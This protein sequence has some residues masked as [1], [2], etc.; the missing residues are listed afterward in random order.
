MRILVTGCA[1]FIGYA[2]CDELLRTENEVLGI[3]R[4]SDYYSVDLKKLRLNRLGIQK[5]FDF[6]QTDIASEKTTKSIT[7][8][9]P[10]VVL[11]LAA[12]PGVRKKTNKYWEYVSDNIISF[13][14]LAES[15]KKSNINMFMYAS[16]S[17]IYGVQHKKIFAENLT[18]LRPTSFYGSTKL[19]NEIFCN[20]FFNGT[21]TKTVGLRFFTVYG[22]F[23]RPDMSYMRLINAALN[24][25]R[26]KS[27]GNGQIKRDFTY[28]D[29]VVSSIIKLIKVTNGQ[30]EISPKIYNIGGGNPIS[31]NQLVAIVEKNTNR[32]I[33]IDFQKSL[34]EDLPFTKSST[35]KLQKA[36]GFKP[37]IKIEDGINRTVQWIIQNNLELKLNR[38]IKSVD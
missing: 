31:I 26:Y 3:D 1:G 32:K 16:S 27:Y 23:G 37:K 15:V 12:Q 5:N 19:I 4:L 7:S 14:K 17:S 21:K 9:K 33:K 8:F 13:S 18:D 11:N 34:K 28:I 38:W 6:V 29:D 10:D 24:N 2:V 25:K 22:P 30:R 35:K 20:N 36:T